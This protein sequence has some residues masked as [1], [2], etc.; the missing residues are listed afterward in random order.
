MK[1]V[2]CSTCPFMEKEKVEKGL[3]NRFCHFGPPVA[4]G[5]GF[6]FPLVKRDAYCSHHP[7]LKKPPMIGVP[8]INLGSLDIT[9]IGDPS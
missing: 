6:M 4:Y 1:K 7:D 5:M 9:L 3:I 2:S 8:A